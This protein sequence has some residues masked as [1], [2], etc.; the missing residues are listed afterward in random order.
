MSEKRLSIQRVSLRFGGV[1]ALDAVTLDLEAGHI[2]GVIGPNGA[3]KS[4]LVN[5]I[6]GSYQP[7]E[8][9]VKLDGREVLSLAPH[10]RAAMGLSRTFQNLALFRGMS[11]F[12]NAMVGRHLRIRDGMLSSML[13]LPKA[14]ASRA[15]RESAA[16]VERLLKRLD[17]GHLRD[18]D[19]SSLPY[20]YQKRVELA[21]A[22]ASEAR[23]ILLDEPFAGMT[24]A[25]S[26]DM[27]KVILELWQERNLTLMIIEHNMGLIMDV[28]DRVAVLD[29]GR[30]VAHGEPDE[31]RSN[32]E[33]IRAYLG[34][35]QAA[36][37]A[38]S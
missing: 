12:D 24:Q 10:R 28:A 26:R 8:G 1:T 37:A 38:E 13:P 29:F 14:V 19:V 21:R 2:L 3:G 33:V 30:L 27:A 20:G 32:P 18:H 22:L 16:L 34:G 15:E 4:S 23:L 25:E 17:L 31:I 11:V 35:A 6:C 7:N 36:V 5:I 9:S